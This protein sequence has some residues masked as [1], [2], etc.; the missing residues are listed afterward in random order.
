MRSDARIQDIL[1]TLSDPEDFVRG[2]LGNFITEGFNRDEAV[3]RI[4]ISGTGAAP[5]Y[6]IEQGSK[7]SALPSSGL[8][9][10]GYGRRAV[11]HGRSHK[12]I[13]DD[14]PKGISWSSAAMTFADVQ[15]ILGSFRTRKGVR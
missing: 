8:E 14:D 6:C 4:G 7:T 2:I 9:V 10:T 1:H 13:L 12:P 5:H 15:A 11:F 3:V